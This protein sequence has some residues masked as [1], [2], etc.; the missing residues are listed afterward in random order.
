MEFSTVVDGNSTARTR[1]YDDDDMDRTDV[2]TTDYHH[3]HPPP[4]SSTPIHPSVNHPYRQQLNVY[5]LEDE[6]EDMIMDS[7]QQ[8]Q[9]QQQPTTTNHESEM[10]EIADCSSFALST[11]VDHANVMSASSICNNTRAFLSVLNRNSVDDRLPSTDRDAT[12]TISNTKNDDTINSNKPVIF[13]LNYSCYRI[14]LEI[15]STS[16]TSAEFIIANGNC[17]EEESS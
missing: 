1:I 10:M 2:D 9:Y 4:F 12:M 6:E 14:F 5:G 3:R 13:L 15:R 11:A 17:E 8:Q 16:Y 7:P